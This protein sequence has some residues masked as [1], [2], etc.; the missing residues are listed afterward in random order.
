MLFEKM[1]VLEYVAYTDL[2]IP[3]GGSRGILSFVIF[4]MTLYPAPP[5]PVTDGD[6]IPVF[7]AYQETF[8]LL[9]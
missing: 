4:R 1:L 2:A 8:G 5:L 3:G 7:W 9:Q 6:T